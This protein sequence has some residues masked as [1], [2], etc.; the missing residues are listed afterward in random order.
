[1]N[2]VVLGLGNLLCSDDGLG[3]HAL[4]R[5]AGDRRLPDG[6]RL[7]EGGVAGLALL[8]EVAGATHLLILDGVDAGAPP[9]RLL[10]FD[11][12]RLARLPG[13]GD[14][15]ALA[16]AD[17][18]CALRLIGREPADVVL[19]GVQVATT[20]VGLGLSP[21]VESRLPDVVDAAIAQFARWGA[22]R[23]GGSDPE[24]RFQG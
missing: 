17:L 16:L 2:C 1:M 9:G 8:A 7:V 23:S 4:R 3:V 15:H 12:S 19:V 13:G 6:V 20:R 22:V 5:L 10:R 21:A 24:R 14:A 11:A 18:L